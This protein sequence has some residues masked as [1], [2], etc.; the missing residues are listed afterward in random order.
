MAGTGI[1]PVVRAERRAL[2]ADLG[3]L[4]DEQ[5]AA[6]SLCSEWTVRDVVGHM[7]ATAQITLASFFPKLVGAG[8]S[9]MRMQEKDL[10]AGRQGSNADALARFEAIVG[11]E[12]HPPGPPDTWLGEVLV[13]SQDVRRPLGL[14]HDEPL[15]AWQRVADFYKR[16]NLVIGAKRRVAGLTLRATDI[17]WATGSG[18]EV[19]GPIVS[20]VLAMSGRTAALD[21]LAGD[22]LATLRSRS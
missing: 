7:T 14:A 6:P 16:S 15:E 2:V 3:G 19:N 18:P 9:L 10:A 11:S 4:A 8:F 12:K 17:G 22:G 1:W 5:W 21:D 13:H 20:I